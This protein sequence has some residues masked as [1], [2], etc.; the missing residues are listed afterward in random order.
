[1]PVVVV[2]LVVAGPIMSQPIGPRGAPLVSFPS[3][4][5]P[6]P[7]FGKAGV[8]TGWSYYGLPNGPTTAVVDA[9]VGKYHWGWEGAPNRLPG[10]WSRYLNCYGPPTATYLPLAAIAPSCDA[11]KCFVTPPRFGY[12]LHSFGY[13]SASPRLASPTV[14]SHPAPAGGSTAC[15]RVDVRLPQADAELWVNRTKTAATGTDRTFES[16]ELADGK[17][18]R[19]E[20]VARWKRNGAE[21]SESR[22]VVVTGGKSVVVDFTER[23]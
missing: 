20:L 12:G 17:E 4:V 2:L 11:R 14:S 22:E 8:T 3:F 9:R 23:R 7:A 13:L 5:G 21:V 10:L 18:F 6:A 16:P 15:C 1:L 19:Y